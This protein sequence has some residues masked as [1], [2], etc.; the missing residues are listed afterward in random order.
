MIS[1]KKTLAVV[2]CTLLLMGCGDSSSADSTATANMEAA[3]ILQNIE[4]TPDLLERLLAVSIATQKH[5]CKFAFKRGALKGNKSNA[6]EKW[7]SRPE[8]AELLDENDL[9][10]KEA[11]YGG[12][13]AGV[14]VMKV[15]LQQLQAKTGHAQGSMKTDLHF[16]DDELAAVKVY[17]KKLMQAMHKMYGDMSPAEL[18]AH[19][20]KLKSCG[21]AGT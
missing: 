14:A 11:V 8:V 18:K 12:L 7:A 13:R 1:L 15:G 16:T 20:K 19:M 2:C 4:L 5:P 17:K 10:A 21:V 6:I 9:T 3:N